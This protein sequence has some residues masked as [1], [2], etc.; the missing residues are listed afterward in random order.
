[1]KS[2]IDRKIEYATFQMCVMTALLIVG[3]VTLY[4]TCYGYPF[5]LSSMIISSIWVMI[6]TLI[7]V[8]HALR[9]TDLLLDRFDGTP[10]C[11]VSDMI[12]ED[13]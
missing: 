6:F 2:D 4:V 8:Y 13:E 9:Y 7:I 12:M 1:M 10:M 11:P 3:I 5:H